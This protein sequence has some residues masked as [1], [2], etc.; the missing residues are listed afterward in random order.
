VAELLPP[1]TRA[2]A[3]YAWS[4]NTPTA[5]DLA[6]RRTSLPP[7]GT[8]EAATTVH[9]LLVNPEGDADAAA[10]SLTLNTAGALFGCSS[11]RSFAFG[12]PTDS[13][14]RA[15][16]D[17]IKEADDER[18]FRD[19]VALPFAWAHPGMRWVFAHAWRTIS[20]RVEYYN[21]PAAKKGRVTVMEASDDA[22]K[23]LGEAVNDVAAGQR[24]TP[25]IFAAFCLTTVALL[26]NISHLSGARPTEVGLFV[27]D[28]KGALAFGVAA[29]A[30]FGDSTTTVLEDCTAFLAGATGAPDI[31]TF[32]ACARAVLLVRVD[33]RKGAT[34]AGA[35]SDVKVY[36][37]A[38]FP[39]MG[40]A[41]PAS[42]AALNGI[43]HASMDVPAT[44]SP[45]RAPF[46]AAVR[47]ETYERIPEI[48]ARCFY[49]ILD[50]AGGWKLANGVGNEGG[51]HNLTIY[52]TGRFWLANEVEFLGP[53]VRM[54]PPWCLCSYA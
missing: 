53:K 14:L 3:Q 18:K 26:L 52:G 17:A 49:P 16:A 13:L 20:D 19:S 31:P 48:L 1:A 8:T 34:L 21:D 43:F 2:P 51:K 28:P 12:V 35:D 40:V 6:W 22:G 46:V 47:S 30:F 15:S 37:F 36:T 54:T 9:P 32:L 38:Q 27:D 42:L 7:I 25:A 23:L 44:A 45:E 29:N 41:N 11:G 5:L 24:N 10:W 4:A 33:R 50:V 39:S